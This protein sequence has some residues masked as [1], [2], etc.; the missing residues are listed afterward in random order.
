MMHRLHVPSG[1]VMNGNV[2][3][4]GGVNRWYHQI[5][6]PAVVQDQ[7]GLEPMIPTEIGGTILVLVRHRAELPGVADRST[8][9][10]QARSAQP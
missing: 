3:C 10:T 5:G 2:E 7:P 6:E 9:S 8:C 1:H 4:R